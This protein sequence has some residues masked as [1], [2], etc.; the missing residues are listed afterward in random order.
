MPE[1]LRLR[2]QLGIKRVGNLGA[3]RVRVCTRRRHARPNCPVPQHFAEIARA[4]AA[5][6]ASQRTDCGERF[7][8]R[9]R[10]ET[11]DVRARATEF[12]REQRVE[13]GGGADVSR[14]CAPLRRRAAVHVSVT[15]LPLRGAHR[16]LPQVRTGGSAMRSKAFICAICA[17]VISVACA[18]GA[19]RP[20]PVFRRRV[21]LA[22]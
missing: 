15:N 14:E 20:G 4:A 22:R 11:P 3:T 19:C 10:S 16:R 1:S 2:G 18:R 13:E 9:G 5:L 12:V 21:V 17:C 6:R 7:C 8:Q